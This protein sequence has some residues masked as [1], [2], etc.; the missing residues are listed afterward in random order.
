MSHPYYKQDD[1][2]QLPPGHTL[3]SITFDEIRWQHGIFRCNSI[4]SGRDKKHYVWNGVQ[5]KLGEFEES[6]WYKLAEALI[7]RDH[8][9]GLYEQLLEWETEHNYAGY[10]K[11]ELREEALHIHSM[12]IFDNPEWVDFVP[13]NRRYRPEALASAH[14]VTVV[15]ECCNVPSEVTQEQI[16]RSCN[17]TVCCPHCGRWA[18]FEII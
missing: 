17:G 18:L 12:R 11:K 8:E 5:T 16:N 9:E 3:D 4:G 14:L 7:Q 10:S 15:C 2:I 1:S 13:F 6:A